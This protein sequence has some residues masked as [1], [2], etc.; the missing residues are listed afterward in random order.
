M[1]RGT[2][3]FF[4]V[5]SINRRKGGRGRSLV[6]CLRKMTPASIVPR[7]ECARPFTRSSFW[8]STRH[9]QNPTDGGY[10]YRTTSLAMAAVSDDWASWWRRR[11]DQPDA[12]QR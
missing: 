7:A 4:P 11:T 8:R 3:L 6:R 2:E 1:A 10:S 5:A 12:A 9:R